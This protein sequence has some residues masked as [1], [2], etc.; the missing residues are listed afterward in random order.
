MT[1][2]ILV[3][4]SRRKLR[5]TSHDERAQALCTNFVLQVTNAQGLGM[6]L[7]RRPGESY[8]MIHGTYDI[9]DSRHEGIF[10]FIPPVT[11][12][13]EKQDKFQPK[14]KSHL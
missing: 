1:S 7:G 2:L 4:G 6:R 12:K 5:H 13:L 10:T 9:T 8:H 3:E 14:D 11:E